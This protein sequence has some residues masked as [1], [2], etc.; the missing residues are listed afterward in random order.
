MIKIFQKPFL[1]V[2]LLLSFTQL[3]FSQ[4]QTEKIKGWIV[5]GSIPES[6]EI[7]LENNKERH[8]KVGY[9]KS[10][11]N[12]ID[13]FGSIMQSFEPADFLGKKVKLTAY[14]KTTDVK[15]WCGMWMRVDGQKKG[16]SLSFDNMGDR[17]IKGTTPWTKYEIILYV[18][19]SAINI[20]YGVLTSGTG[21]AL[22][23]NFNFEIVNDNIA[24]TG[25]GG[26]FKLKKPTNTNF[27]E[28][29]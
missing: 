27:E 4:Y 29:N 6:Y 26:L 8:S 7:G 28:S 18:P 17:P 9:L 1:V 15:G 19:E 21:I 16:K 12:K 11:E 20:S 2:L 14:I 25:S 13:G 24:S 23:D 5:T 10:I 22:M 3:S